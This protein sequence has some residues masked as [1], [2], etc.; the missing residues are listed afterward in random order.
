MTNA[1]ISDILNYLCNEARNS[2][3]AS[4]G[5]MEL[6]PASDADTPGDILGAALKKKTKKGDE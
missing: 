5:V 6:L 1:A 2:V 3:H 4:F